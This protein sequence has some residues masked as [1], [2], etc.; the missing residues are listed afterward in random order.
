MPVGTL[1][2]IN[3]VID[4]SYTYTGTNANRVWREEWGCSSSTPPVEL[5]GEPDDGTYGSHWDEDCLQNEFMT[6][7]FGDD[8][9]KSNP[10]SALTIASMKD[11]GY[12]VNETVADD[13][14]GDDTTCCTS[15]SLRR[16]RSIMQSAATRKPL[17]S[18]AGEAAAIA[19]G[20]SQLRANRLPSYL[21]D[22]TTQDNNNSLM[23]F[24]DK[25][26]VVLI[27]ENDVIHDV[28]VTM[29]GPL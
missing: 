25:V 23:Y 29:A 16:T 11:I 1:W 9:G 24:G 4:D 13:Y 17:L 8:E 12:E 22:E 6:G 5:D 18:E 28:I 7:F 27:R 15:Q 19:Y 3:G 2:D 14:D 21:I 10:I 20:R 26:T